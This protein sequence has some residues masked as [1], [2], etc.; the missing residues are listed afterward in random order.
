MALQKIQLR[1]GVVRDQTAYTN[2][3]GWRSSNLVRF[4]LGFPETVGGWQKASTYTFQG[5]C[6]SLHNWMSLSGNDYMAAGTNL[7]YYIEWGGY[8]YNITPIRAVATLNNPFAATNGSS[9][10]V[11]NDV[12]HGA[13][14]NDFVTFS[15]AVSLGGNVT[16]SVLNQTFQVTKVNTSNQYEVTLPVTANASDTGNGGNPVTATY[17]INTGLDTQVGGTGWGAGTW[18]RGTWG[19]AATVS[20]TNTLRVWSQDNY[21]EDLV[22]C[23]RNGGIYYWDASGVTSSTINTR[24]VTLD[25]LS[26]DPMCPT[27]VRQV[28]VSDRDRHVVVF[29]ADYGDGVQDPMAIRF[30]SQEDPFTWTPAPTNTAGDIRLGNGSEILRAVETKRAILVFTDAALYSLQFIGAPY[31]FGVEQISSNVTLMGYNAAT[32][33]DDNVFWMGIDNFY[34]YNGQTLQIECPIKEFVFHDLNLAQSDK[35]F[36]GVNSAF[37]EVTWFYPSLNSSEND[38]YVTFNYAEKVWTYGTLSRTAWLDRSLRKYPI[39]AATGL[40]QN[41]LYYHELGRSDGSTTPASP[42]PAYI[43]SSPID[44]GDGDQFMLLRRIIPDLAIQG[45]TAVSPTVTMSLKMQDYPGQ[46]YTQT[47]SSTVTRTARVP[48]EQ[49]TNQCFV[50]LRGR[51]VVMRVESNEADMGWRL[52]SPR[53]DLV[54]DGRR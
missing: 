23:I 12:A 20:V 4:R 48:I 40:P 37:N 11:V 32:A 29:G 9:T 21:G 30:S 47:D 17:E 14:E 16:A 24:G 19:S 2:E 31:T 27:V 33:I 8:Y 35:V 26:S 51:S 28:L 44:I 45:V 46:N 43:E 3:G 10:L 5:S 42:L 7:R 50:R 34:V 13:V 52:G 1:P 39:A 18:G 54:P 41:F 49:Y 38:R 22:F 36:A 6:R 53:L 15:G 25:S